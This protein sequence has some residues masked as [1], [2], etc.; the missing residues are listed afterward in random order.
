MNIQ[1]FTDLMYDKGI[2]LSFERNEFGYKCQLKSLNNFS[3]EKCFS[4]THQLFNC[5]SVSK[6]N[7]SNKE[8]GVFYS[9]IGFKN[10]LKQIKDWYFEIGLK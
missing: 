6:L 10:C 2:I 5:F 8:I 4:S 1:K 3:L 9:S 7:P